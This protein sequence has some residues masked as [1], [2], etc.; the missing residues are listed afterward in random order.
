MKFTSAMERTAQ[1]EQNYPLLAKACYPRRIVPPTNYPNPKW[2]AGSLGC[3]ILAATNKDLVTD[4]HLTQQ[5][6][7]QTILQYRVPTYFLSPAFAEAV[8]ETD[9]PHDLSLSEMKWPIDALV[10][11]L[12]ESFLARFKKFYAPFLCVTRV[13]Q[14]R[15]PR[16]TALPVI[17]HSLLIGMALR[18]IDNARDRLCIYYPIYFDQVPPFDYCGYFRFTNTMADVDESPMT[19]VTSIEDQLHSF[20]PLYQTPMDAQEEHE[21]NSNWN[22]FAVKI[23]LAL[24]AR[25]QLIEPG[26]IIRPEKVRKKGT[27]SELW[28][29][30]IIG[31]I[32]RRQVDKSAS[33]PTG[34]SVR[35]HWRRGHFRHQRH[36]H[37]LQ[38]VKIIWIDPVMVRADLLVDNV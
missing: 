4:V 21:F 5:L 6:A 22:K 12:P 17:E 1:L 29:P 11:V 18:H 31:R 13:T 34:G 32:Y 24:N 33:V 15:Y 26:A 35:M 27:V 8:W 30:N 20:S 38:E 36:G 7:V 19:D 28:S 14:G 3:Q 23:I 10:F 25:P 37:G 9:L 2:L 16:V